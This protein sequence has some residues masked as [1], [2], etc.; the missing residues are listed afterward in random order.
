MEK[1]HR[2]TLAYTWVKRGEKQAV[3][4]ARLRERVRALGLR[5]KHL[6]LDRA[7]FNVATMKYLQAERL[8]FLMPVVMRGR[9]PKPG[10]KPKGLRVFCKKR[11][12]WYQHT[13][14]SKGKEVTFR[15]CELQ[16]VPAPPDE[17]TRQEE[18]D[19]CSLGNAWLIARGAESLS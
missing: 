18:V 9:K 3:V 1:G 2:F 14:K 5:I 6:L 7:F 16:D 12:G 4:I 11:V 10:Q 17:Q 19:L 15:V 13:M 8:R